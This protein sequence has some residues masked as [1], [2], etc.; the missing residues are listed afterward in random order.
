MRGKIL[1][2]E[3]N[4]IKAEILRLA[5]QYARQV[6]T[7]HRPGSDAVRSFTEGEDPVPYAGRVFTEDEVAAAVSSALDFW[8]TL[9]PEGEKFAQGLAEYLGVKCSVLVNSGSSANLLAVGA[10]TSTKLK[11]K[12]LRPGD[13]VITVAAGFPTTVAPLIQYGLVPVFIDS[14]PVTGNALCDQLGEAFAAG[15]TRAV[16]LAHTLGNPFDLAACQSFCQQHGLWLIEDNCDALGATYD[17]RLTGTFGDLSTQS[18]YPPHHLTLGEGGAVNVVKSKRFKV[19][20]E[21]LRDWGR[22]C[23][24]PSG[25][26]NT[27]GRRFEWQLGDLPKGYDHKYTYSHLGYNL[28]PLDLQAAI[29]VEQLKKLPE[30]TQA[31]VANWDYLRGGLRDLEEYFEFAL[32]THATG[33]TPEGFV[34]DESGHQTVPSWFGF[35]FL[36]R[37]S[38]PFTKFE[39]AG[40]L[41]EKKI[42]NRMV[43]GGNLVRQPA[44]VDLRQDRPKA[45]RVVGDLSGADRIMNEAIFIGVY[46]GL[47]QPML[48][49]VVE[50][51]HAFVS[52]KRAS[53]AGD[54]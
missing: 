38:A 17:G 29:G 30:F 1:G 36:V 24:C 39:F 19:I 2:P 41:D 12:R 49:Y 32:P 3:A 43:F 51:I 8:L 44:L 40:Y 28:K 23:Y 37:R 47:T 11:E 18:F 9:G 53:S 25:A 52:R 15:K 31:R 16:I 27:C 35:T 6:H 14:D 42:G 13:E 4:D 10:L 22:A 45:F 20:V 21:S 7:G 48:D 54:P 50:S 34:W 5:R 33:W 46:P 26:D